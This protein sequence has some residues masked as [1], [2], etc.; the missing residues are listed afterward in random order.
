MLQM[1]PEGVDNIHTLV[2]TING[3]VGDVTS[4]KPYFIHV[5]F[6]DN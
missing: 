6:P 4:F 3:I 5:C 1:D 2:N